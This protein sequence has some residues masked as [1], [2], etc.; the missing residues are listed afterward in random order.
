MTKEQYDK[1][2]DYFRWIENYKGNIETLEKVI[3][4]QEKWQITPVWV[5]IRGEACPIDHE[6]AMT[7]LK[8]RLKI[9]NEELD[10]TI[11]ELE[12]I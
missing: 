12:E 10:R 11:K 5:T 9:L 2:T 1:A 6:S 8:G 7:I 3:K 4:E